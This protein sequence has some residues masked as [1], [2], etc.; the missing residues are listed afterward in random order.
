MLRDSKFWILMAVFQACF[1][2][3]VFAITRDHY[4]PRAQGVRAHPSTISPSASTWQGI[5]ES[6]IS[7]LAPAAFGEASFQ[8]PA[9]ISRRADEFFAGRQYEQAANWY[10][11]L[12]DFDA[13]NVEVHN[14]LGLT[15]HYLGRSDEA[16]RYLN[17]GVALDSTNQR[18]WLTLGYVNSQLGNVEQARMALGKATQT[19][20]NESIRQSALSMLDELP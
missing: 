10:K 8:D 15:L 2:F 14:N 6:D 18:I 11:R 5:R 9:E 1:G 16:L 12:L 19:G 3:A 17:E 13:R 4:Q 7:R 20:E